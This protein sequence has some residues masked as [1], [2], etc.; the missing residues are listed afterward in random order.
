MEEQLGVKEVVEILEGL[1]VVSQVTGEV[2]EDGK[3]SVADLSHLLT[4][5]KKFDTLKAAVEGAGGSLKEIKDLN[6]EEVAI[7]LGKTYEVVKVFIEAKK[8]GPMPE[9]AGA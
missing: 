4:F 5:M 2:L 9:V 1:K 8:P 6:Q 7:V 3:V